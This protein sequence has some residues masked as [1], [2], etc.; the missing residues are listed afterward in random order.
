MIDWFKT[1][2]TAEQ[3]LWPVAVIFT[4]IFFYQIIFTL[5]K[6]RPD[7]KRKFLFS[8]FF[9]FKNI[10]AFFSMFGWMTIACIY[11]NIPFV[12][13]LIIGIGSGLMLMAVMSILFFYTQKL[14]ENKALTKKSKGAI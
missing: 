5:I 2:N 7:R 8:H 1:L 13:S 10:T 11:Q 3:V 12:T 4:L 9:A 14:K 6:R